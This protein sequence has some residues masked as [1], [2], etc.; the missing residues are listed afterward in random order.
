MNKKIKRINMQR[1]VFL[2]TF[3]LLG[4]TICYQLGAFALEVEPTVQIITDIDS[5]IALLTD[6]PVSVEDIL[7]SSV[8][9]DA[10]VSLVDKQSYDDLPKSDKRALRQ[11][12]K[13]EF[14]DEKMITFIGNS[15]TLDQYEIYDALGV[16]DTVIIESADKDAEEMEQYL[17]SFSVQEKD[18]TLHI[19]R[20]YYVPE[21]DHLAD[22]KKNV[23]TVIENAKD[24]VIVDQDSNTLTASAASNSVVNNYDFKETYNLDKSGG[25][26]KLSIIKFI[27]KKANSSYTMW[28]VESADY[29]ETKTTYIDYIEQRVSVDGYAG[30]SLY[31]VRPN[32]SVGQNVTF[33]TSLSNG[34]VSIGGSFSSGGGKITDQSSISRNY[35]QWKFQL[36][37]LWTGNHPDNYCSR[38]SALFKNSSGAFNLYFRTTVGIQGNTSGGGTAKINCG[39]KTLKF[40]D[41]GVKIK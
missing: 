16:D 13:D 30:E 34:G 21:D 27:S 32:N 3:L 20:S 12:I 33:N 9:T 28:G 1:K 37:A 19:S 6:D 35:A 14:E 25:P 36:A 7:D 17:N 41:R 31:A 18:G 2:L 5:E 10:D 4:T 26:S 22:E 11:F 38:S 29:T 15:E 23:E 8:S 24:D 40:S 39:M